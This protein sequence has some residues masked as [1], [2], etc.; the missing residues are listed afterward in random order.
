MKI[1]RFLAALTV[2]AAVLSCQK[3]QIAETPA[4]PLP[5]EIAPQGDVDVIDANLYSGTEFAAL[6]EGVEVNPETKCAALS[7]EI[8]RLSYQ[9]INGKGEP[10]T[11]SMKLAYPEGILTKYHDPKFIVLDNHPT[12]CSQAESPYEKNPI[13]LAKALEDALVVCPDYEGFGISVGNDHPYLCQDLNARQSVDA[14]LAAIDY[15]NARKGIKMKSGY[16]LENYGYSQGGG[17][18]LS[19]HKYIE[20]SLSP[21]DQAKLNL[22]KSVCGGGTYN[23]PLMMDIYLDVDDNVYPAIL[24]LMLIG[25]QSAYPQIM[26]GFELSDFLRAEFLATGIADR[27][28][29]KQYTIDELNEF[30]EKT[31]GTKLYSQMLVPEFYDETSAIRQAFDQCLA[32]ADATQGWTPVKNVTLFHSAKDQIVPVENALSAYESLK[33]GNI[34]PIEW[35]L[36]APEHRVAAALF[37]VKMMGLNIVPGLIGQL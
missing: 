27:I 36:L 14:V 22:K 1:F 15:I 20:N 11:L 21:A 35:A 9:S 31:Y 25:F 13:A 24:P 12:I 32:N 5:E 28:R 8:T 2:S 10:V 29:S 33:G 16:Y 4:T 37:Y 18:A 17:I 26:D 34:S 23:L 7:Y 19:V 6:F 3:G 30:I